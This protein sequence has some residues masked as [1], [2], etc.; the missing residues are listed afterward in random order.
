MPLPIF[1]EMIQYVVHNSLE[2]AISISRCSKSFNKI[3]N[4]DSIWFEEYRFRFGTV[5]PSLFK[6]Y[7]YTISQLSCMT[8]R[9]L[10]G[11]EIGWKK[12]YVKK[13]GNYLRAAFAEHSNYVQKAP[14]RVDELIDFFLTFNNVTPNITNYLGMGKLINISYARSAVDTSCVLIMFGSE[15]PDIPEICDD[16]KRTIYEYLTNWRNWWITLGKERSPNPKY[17]LKREAM[18]LEHV[19]KNTLHTLQDLTQYVERCS[20]YINC[21]DPISGVTPLQLSTMRHENKE[22]TQFLILHGANEIGWKKN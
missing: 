2:A 22:K 17:V 16:E 9:K 7:K 11:Q 3:V 6:E 8:E 21:A 20:P 4:D 10:M 19:S 1:I 14:S 12:I 5:P 15:L 13:I 18:L